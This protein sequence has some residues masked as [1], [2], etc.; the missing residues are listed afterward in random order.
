MILSFAQEKG[1]DFKSALK[2]SLTNF[3]ISKSARRKLRYNL[4]M[5]Y[6][7]INLT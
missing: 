6:N 7:V 2:A 3:K 1:Q 4:R 5:Q